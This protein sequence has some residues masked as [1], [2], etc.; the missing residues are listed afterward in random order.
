MEAVYTKIRMALLI[1]FKGSAL[2]VCGVIKKHANVSPN[3]H[4]K[5]LLHHRI[6][7]THKKRHKT[8]H[9]PKKIVGNSIVL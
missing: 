2:P 5:N 7:T 6:G 3:S 1:L 4:K 8:A 9:I